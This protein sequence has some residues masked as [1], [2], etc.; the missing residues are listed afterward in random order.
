MARPITHV[1]LGACV[2][3]L[4]IVTGPFLQFPIG[5]IVPVS[6][7]AWFR[8]GRWGFTLA[9]ALP[10]GRILIAHYIEHPHPL[11]YIVANGAIRIIVLASLAY[12]VARTARQTRELERKVRQLEGLLP[13][14]MF[15]KRIRDEHQNWQQIERYISRHSEA[16]FSH[17]LC[18]ECAK[19]HYG[20][21]LAEHAEGRREDRD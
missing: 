14:C 3:A 19:K 2:L 8:G 9:V 20:D 5:F 7:A 18:P 11:S 21:F 13:I 10:I 6:L 12:L 4:D 1:L 16:E 17:G 15:C